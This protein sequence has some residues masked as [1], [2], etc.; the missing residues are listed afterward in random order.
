MRKVRVLFVAAALV[1]GAVTATALPA[2]ADQSKKLSEQLGALWSTVLETPSAQNPFGDGGIAYACIGLGGHVLSPLRPAGPDSATCT[3]RPGT[4]VLVPALVAECSTIEG[5]G[6]TEAELRACAE[7]LNQPSPP[8]VTLDGSA[9]AV[10]RVGTALLPLVMPADNIFG[11]P[12]GTTGQSVGD[13]W[14][15]LLP[16]LPPGTHHIRIDNDVFT[17]HPTIIVEA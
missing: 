6:T 14:V 12:A 9:V 3:V 13:G 7:N 10:T 17:D 15:A 8:T 4:K 11:V 2:G 1:F 5:D 16:P